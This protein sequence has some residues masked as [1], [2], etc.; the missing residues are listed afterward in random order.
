MQRPSCGSTRNSF[1]W[2]PCPS[3][4]VHRRP[5]P[6]GGHRYQFTSWHCPSAGPGAAV[7]SIVACCN[8]ILVPLNTN[9]TSAELQEELKR[10]RLDALIVSGNSD[11]SKRSCAAGTVLS[12]RRRHETVH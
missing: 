4:R 12:Y 8:A 3:R 5:A 10:I 1:L 2:G 6:S 7:L 9:L 11:T